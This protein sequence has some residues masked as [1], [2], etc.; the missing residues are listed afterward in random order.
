MSELFEKLCKLSD[1]CFIGNVQQTK[2]IVIDMMKPYADEIKT[3]ITGS[4]IAKIK[5]TSNRSILL[6]AHIDEIGFVVTKV[7]SGG[8]VRMQNVG[9]IDIR[10][11]P[12]AMITIHGKRDVKGVFT[13]TPPHLAVKGEKDKF[14][15]FDEIM[16]DTG[17]ENAEDIIST[18]DFATFDVKPAKLCK[19]YVSGKSLDNRTGVLSL[20]RAAELI[21]E[22]GKPEDTIYFAFT[23]GEELGNRGAKIA[24][25]DIAPNEAVAVDVSFGLSP[26]A[27]EQHCG[28]CGNGG[29]IGISPILS[30]DVIDKLTDAADKNNIKYQLEVMGGRTST[31]ADVISITKSGVACGLVSVPL[32]YMHT[33]IEVV[34]ITDIESVAQIL[35]EYTRLETEE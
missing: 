23:S 3:D 33:P 4:V 14:P 2:D 18:G 15:G 31:D 7:L 21:H 24:A 26:N 9:G 16:V 8:F 28:I 1:S 25:F 11:L 32:R 5:G 22:S 27:P 30:R 20:I 34:D 35:F 19:D 12:S 10:T 13:S 29:M 17:L 6:Q